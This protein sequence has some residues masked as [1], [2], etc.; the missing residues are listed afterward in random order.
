MQKQ[1]RCTICGSRFAEKKCYYCE[2]RICTSCMVPVEVSGSTT[3]CLTCDRN[4][5]N[6]L[7]LVQMLKRNY[8]LFAIIVAFWLFTVFPIPFLHLAGIEVDPSAFQPV[9]I[10]TGAMTIPFVFLFL[11]WQRKAPRGSS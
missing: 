11:A 7:S 6:R 9:L 2:S 10:A 5:V 4:K 8:Y 3:K 1:D